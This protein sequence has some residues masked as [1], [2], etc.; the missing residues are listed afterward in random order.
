M[1]FGYCKKERLA[2]VWDHQRSKP[3]Q[4]PKRSD[5]KRNLSQRLR[6]SLIIRQCTRSNVSKTYFSMLHC[7]ESENVVPKD[8]SRRFTPKSHRLMRAVAQWIR[9]ERPPVNY[10]C[11]KLASVGCII[12]VCNFSM[13]VRN[14]SRAF[15]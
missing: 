12:L 13:V 15:D 11:L 3:L 10:L 4:P 8:E 5:I 7:G 1:R 14:R 6:S 2:L 9:Q